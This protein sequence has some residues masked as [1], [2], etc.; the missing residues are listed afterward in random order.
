MLKRK[1]LTAEDYI[2]GILN[3]NRFVLSRAITLL[4]S[5]LESDSMLSQKIL[6]K[7]LPK[8]GNAVRVGITGVPG[9][10]KSTFIESFGEYIIQQGINV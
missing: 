8:T 4:E 2:N 7:I 9:V 5:S 3:G 1:R 10:G 6:E